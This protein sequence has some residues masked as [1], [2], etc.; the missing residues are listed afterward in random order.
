VEQC[1]AAIR[2]LVSGR[3]L[4][5]RDDADLEELHLDSTSIKARASA[6]GSRRRPGEKKR[7][8]IDAER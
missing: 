1:L 3:R 2:P 8:P 4:A 7:T 6:A 5:L